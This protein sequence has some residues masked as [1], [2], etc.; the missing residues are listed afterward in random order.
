MAALSLEYDDLPAGSDLRREYRPAGVSIAVGGAEPSQR[1]LRVAR[2]REALRAGFDTAV[3][4]CII[5]ALGVLLLPNDVPRRVRLANLPIAV[6]PLFGL[7]GA[8]LYLLFWR[9]GCAG[10][11]DQANRLGQ[12]ETSA[13]AA[14][15]AG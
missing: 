7:F 2:Q 4:L 12:G 9:Q 5:L 3:A 13:G 6:Y 11:A 15:R 1:A 10:R 8:A 14:D